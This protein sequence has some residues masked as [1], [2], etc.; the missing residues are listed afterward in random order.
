MLYFMYILSVVN[1]G[2]CRRGGGGNVFG[3][4]MYGGGE[5]V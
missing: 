1:C 3:W 4:G 2:V 5:N